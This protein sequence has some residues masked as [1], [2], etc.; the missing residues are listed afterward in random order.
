M[1]DSAV[2]FAATVARP[3]GPAPR[4]RLVAITESRP[5]FARSAETDNNSLVIGVS[6]L[7][8]STQNRLAQQ[9]DTAGRK[10]DKANFARP[11]V[12]FI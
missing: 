10:Q 4:D 1:S 9:A 2:C 12:D 6:E 11:A 7:A 3:D 5:R 8:N